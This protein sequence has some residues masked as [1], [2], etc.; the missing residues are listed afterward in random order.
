MMNQP[1]RR[2][3]SYLRAN[4]LNAKNGETLQTALTRCL[5]VFP[6]SDATKLLVGVR[7]FSIRHRQVDDNHFRIHIASWTE[8]EDAATVP[9][10]LGNQ[11]NADLAMRPPDPSTDYL[12]GDAF[13]V[14]AD[15]HF[16]F[17]PSGVQRKTV[18]NYLY[19]LL[20]HSHRKGSIPTE[21]LS[22]FD[23]FPVANRSVAQQLREEG[24]KEIRL[25]V[26]QYLESAL[27][28]SLEAQPTRLQSLGND[29][30]RH[31]ITRETDREEIRRSQNVQAELV[32][33]VDGRRKGLDY[34]QFGTMMKDVSDEAEDQDIVLVTRNNHRIKHGKL[35]LTKP[36][37][38]TPFANTVHYRSAWHEMEVYL[39]ELSKMRA[40]GV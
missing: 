18:E 12:G 3:I 27:S 36:V 4:W 38:V 23:L 24:L 31:L 25:N 21:E 26:G 39:L 35:L 40:L 37:D 29:F 34:A 19:R 10:S 5:K 28:D 9:H 6:S 11:A 2:T 32:I 20:Q 15:N 30:L 16:V 22:D 17:M 8:G 14:V 13:V 1:R 33:K 7:E